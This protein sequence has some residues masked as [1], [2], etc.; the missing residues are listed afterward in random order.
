MYASMR[1]DLALAL[2][3]ERVDAGL[4]RASQSAKPPDRRRPARSRFRLR[5]R[6]A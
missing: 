6:L 4:R 2:H 3:R 1:P 5:L